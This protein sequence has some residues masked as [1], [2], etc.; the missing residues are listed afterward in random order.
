MNPPPRRELPEKVLAGLLAVCGA[1][2]L[3]V[4]MAQQD[5]GKEVSPWAWVG[6]GLF[7]AGALAAYQWHWLWWAM[8]P[9]LMLDPELLPAPFDWDEVYRRMNA[10]YD[11][12]EAAEASPEENDGVY[13][14]AHDAVTLGYVDTVRDMLKSYDGSVT[15]HPIEPELGTDQ[16][17]RACFVSSTDIW[18]LD[19]PV[20]LPSTHRSN[21]L[22]LVDRIDAE[23]RLR[24][25]GPWRMT[26][27]HG[28]AIDP[29]TG[30]V[31]DRPDEFPTAPGISDMF[32]PRNVIGA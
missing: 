30:E 31:A 4:A 32:G 9:P 25:D 28:R 5:A 18:K 29:S 2:L 24:P 8:H 12:E 1:Y 3:T 11:S 19:P 22:L 27:L 20:V 21:K 7:A 16:S 13:L 15:H 6:V 26:V 17:G 23:A 10:Y 14:A